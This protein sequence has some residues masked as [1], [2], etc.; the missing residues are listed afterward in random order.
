MS[1]HAASL[2]G[3]ACGSLIGVR[4]VVKG[5][6]G[7]FLLAGKQMA[8]QRLLFVLAGDQIKKN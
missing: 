7:V 1:K 8:L 4:Q 6:G 5:A 2:R 3:A